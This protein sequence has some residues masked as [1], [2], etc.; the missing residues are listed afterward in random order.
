[1]A[2]GAALAIAL[3]ARGELAD[4]I[5]RLELAD[6]LEGVFFHSASLPGGPVLARRPPAEAR[7]ALSLMITASPNDARL[8]ALRARE[9]ELIL[10][11]AAAEAD[12]KRSGNAL[13]LADFYHR[14]LRPA[15]EI[16]VLRAAGE[17]ERAIAVAPSVDLYRAWIA[18]APKEPA[19]Y[20]HFL[21]YLT[22]QGDW[23]A[24]E[25]LLDEYATAFPADDIF[26]VRARAAIER[27]RGS[28]ERAIAIYEKAF[29]PLWP[30][31]LAKE[32]IA[33]VRES[34][35]LRR[36]LDRLRAAV[37]AAPLDLGPAARLFYFHQQQGNPAAAER[38]LLD[39]RRRKEARKAA[40]TSAE[41]LALGRLFEAVHSYDEAA[42]AW[43]GLYSLD[44]EEGL[45]SMAGLLLSAPEQPV[46]FGAGDLSFY[47]DVA[48]MDAGPGLLNGI[49]SLILN[50]TALAS[51]YALQER[52][53]AAYFHR[54]RGAELVALLDARF[55]QS[56]RRAGLH[57]Q[58]I[59]AYAT[60]GESEAVITAGRR[61]LTDFPAAAE[62]VRVSLAMADAYAR[63]KREKE[64]FA[65][66]DAL[67][68]ELGR[69]AG[70]VPLGARAAPS[71]AATAEP[72][73]PESGGPSARFGLAG[74]PNRSAPSVEGAHSP[75]Y[76][77]VL[78]RTIA[79]LVL[80]KR[81]KDAMALYRRQIDRN[82]N[83]PG[84]YER[85]AAFL[86]QNKL[87]AEV[88]QVYR[89]AMA[90]FPDRSWHHKLARWYLRRKQM[91]EFDALTRDVAKVFAGSDLER[92]FTEIV[93]PASL[94]A[95]LYRQVNLYAHSRFP[96]DLVFVRNLLTAYMRRGTADPAAWEALIRNY[97]FYDDELRARFFEFLSRTNRL[98]AELQAA[99]A[100]AATPVVVRFAGEAEIW[101]CHF[102]AAAPRM[103]ALAEAC[104][105]CRETAG[106]AAALERSLGNWEAASAIEQKL[107]EYDPRD[108]AT[109]AR[110]GE[111]YADR[112]D[113]ARAR[114]WWTRIAAI[115]PGKAGG[116]LES[117]TV[118]WDYFLYDDALAQLE[119][120]RKRLAG[121]ALYAYEAGAIYENKRDYARAI[122]EYARG[123]SRGQAR[124][125]ALARRPA[126]RDAIESLTAKLAAGVD[127]DPGA[128]NLRVALLEAQGRR[129]DLERYL[130][131]L[132][133]SAGTLEV[134]ARVREIAGRQ[135]FTRVQEQAL[136][137][138]V[139]LEIEAGDKIRA[140]L[141]LIRF[142]ESGGN[143]AAA[144]QGMEAL[145]RENSRV[146]G[147]VRAAADFFWRNR[148]AA[149]AVEVLEQA[150]RAAYP[151]LSRQLTLEAGKKATEAADYRKARA[152]LA[153]LLEQDPLRQEYAAA[154][155]DVFARQGDDKGLRDFYTARLQL[156]HD[157]DQSAALRRL[158]IPVLE[159][160]KDFPA[161]LAEYG[162]LLNRYP[163]DEGLAREAAAFATAHNLGPRLVA[164]YEKAA[165]ESPRDARWP[166]I[167]ARLQTEFENAPAAVAAYE[168]AGA[169]RPERTD[170]LEARAGLEERLM[171]FDTAAGTYAKLYE[172]A[173]RNPRWMKKAAEMRARGGRQAEALAALR[174]AL[175]DGKPARAAAFFEAAEALE[176]WG[177]LP[178]AR[179]MAE[180]GVALCT[181]EELNTASVYA[182]VMTRLRQYEPA[183]QRLAPGG[184][185]A[186]AQMAQVVRGDYAPAERAAFAAFLERQKTPERMLWLIELVRSA[187]LADLEARWR[188]ERML[189]EAGQPAAEMELPLLILLQGRRGRFGELGAQLE[190]YWNADPRKDKRDGV[191][192]MAAEAYRSAGDAPGELRALER[193]AGLS[194]RARD[195]YF[196]LLRSLRPQGL[197]D[198]AARDEAA[199]NFAM[200]SGD[201]A[202]ALAAIE[203]RGR[204]RAP[205]WTRAYTS[206]AGLH[207]ARATPQVRAAFT[208]T[209]GGGAVS[210]R[211]GRP[212]DR[213][214]GLAGDVWFYY[215]SRYGE[216]LSAAGDAGAEDYLPAVLEAT[217]GRAEAYYLLAEFYREKG[218]RDRALAD[219]ERAIQLDP[220]RA[221]AHNRVAGMFAAQG[222]MVEA[223]ARLRMA[224]EALAARQD[225]RRPPPSF[226]DD[227]SAVLESAG[228]YGVL[229][230]LR[231]DF[232]KLLRT[233]VRRNGPFRAETILGAAVAAAGKPAGAEWLVDQAASAPDPLVFLEALVEAPWVGDGE[234]DVLLPRLVALA[235]R[236]N[237]RWQVRWIEHLLAT[238][239]LGEA[240]QALAAIR[241]DA[242]KTR[243]YE[244][245]RLEI[246]AAARAGRLV[247]LIDR[248]RREPESAPPADRLREFSSDLRKEGDRVSAAR[249]M[250]FANA[251]EIASGE[252][253]PAAFLGLAEALLEQGDAARAV[254]VLR[255]MTL[256]A[257]DPFSNLGEAA[258]LLTRFGRA[259]EAREFLDADRKASPWKAAAAAAPVVGA[260]DA[261][262][263][264]GD[265]DRPGLRVALFR[266][267]LDAGQARL[268]VSTMQP[269]WESGGLKHLLESEPAAAEESD[270]RYSSYAFHAGQFLAG[271]DLDAAGRAALARRL[272]AAFETI[273]QPPAA[274]AFFR[275]SREIAPSAEA[276]AAIARLRAEFARRAANE[277]RR[278]MVRDILD[279]PHIVRPR[280][281][282]GN[283]GSAR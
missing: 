261:E 45:V 95:A 235:G 201:A 158:L 84:L 159:R 4:Y 247:A 85:L 155:A 160:M 103:R 49:L 273:G 26:P 86:E 202:L 219:Y 141:A 177:M 167:L 240:Q 207:Y 90:Q 69:Q 281:E 108:T 92:Y 127:P 265:P 182:R 43:H 157:A 88:E 191:L 96:H 173:Y 270:P 215:G 104:P 77:R 61:F 269:T 106:R 63:G 278:P 196:A 230:A 267:A 189:A 125:I 122:G 217:P 29:R 275:I 143:L 105:G 163:E 19:V 39:F 172:L 231:A 236:E 142:Q 15:D 262:A 40:W 272:A 148:D 246:R 107:S 153:A 133:G 183:F 193:S 251:R 51:Q 75:E 91:A 80:L 188:Y 65:V 279:Q 241:A 239:R 73:E 6:R 32:H 218:D 274:L 144:R 18:R 117:A 124:L 12:W 146:R 46:R 48:T 205:V 28:L 121:A 135:G 204:S 99:R 248:Y 3:A 254:G 76:A 277:R 198:R 228:R 9:S 30:A 68:D 226:W 126:H 271:T 206:L 222:R 115:E 185:G 93:M 268:A 60:Y 11:F 264:A 70:G 178:E 114:P 36:Y 176:S 83:D 120:G 81:I 179:G 112:E 98:Q 134:T 67:L 259:A 21:D 38:A 1:L 100:Q 282:A 22:A 152:L 62:R 102:E 192:E 131:A 74:M 8:Y 245:E 33:L 156:I 242:R 256:V 233:Y 221:D 186:L 149:R 164:R 78:D 190:A 237:L 151:E 34:R 50:S 44:P 37:A 150:A 140:R 138:E 208:A 229:A 54:A 10:D 128:V 64:E 234:R 200:A 52:N 87:A 199:A 220:R 211:I 181:P 13:E 227:T 129:A 25:R 250:E 213:R 168:K 170:F 97:W 171:R 47:K 145:Y 56:A 137:R 24:A 203:S 174:Q 110:I 180:K 94:D 132:A 223:T 17:F 210:E 79:R 123:D 184:P 35:G 72:E 71:A 57:A 162:E 7:Q 266:A 27:R 101:L 169:I 109:L 212:V 280:L 111:I 23:P 232:D 258:R 119:R 113:F 197:I 225:E 195:R 276:E 243:I 20:R 147:V 139:A 118:F 53:A 224:I 154:M 58:L 257:N 214:E 244:I 187:G 116:Y 66:Y 59:D 252:R 89:R 255:R 136:A 249:L 165:V 16:E 5:Q 263:L 216:Y 82:P 2:A 253:G 260:V 238:R 166:L 283:G 14:R 130:A 175:I 31:E 41:L 42:R 161:A 209:L 55:P 194:M